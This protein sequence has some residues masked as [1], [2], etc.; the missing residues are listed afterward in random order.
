MIYVAMN[1]FIYEISRQ[2]GKHS[3]NSNKIIIYHFC[4]FVLFPA[5][6][7]K[8]G[9]VYPTVYNSAKGYVSDIVVYNNATYP[10]M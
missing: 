3:T 8:I 7:M 9:P 6:H 4:D 5:V 2:T 1:D 10:I